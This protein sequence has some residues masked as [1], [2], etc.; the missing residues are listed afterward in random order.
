[1]GADNSKYSD[2]GLGTLPMVVISSARSTL[3]FGMV[4]VPTLYKL[5]LEM[6]WSLNPSLI[7]INPLWFKGLTSRT[8]DGDNDAAYI[9]A[10]M[11]NKKV[12][13]YLMHD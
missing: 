9:A 1:M 8:D 2:P 13:G 3:P 10:P 11:A 6:H 12:S 4:M 5:E 7:N